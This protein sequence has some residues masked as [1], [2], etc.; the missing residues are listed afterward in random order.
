MLV[1]ALV[2][3]AVSLLFGYVFLIAFVVVGVAHLLGIS[4]IWTALVVGL[5][6]IL[7][8]ALFVSSLS[9]GPGEAPDV[10]DTAL[11]FERGYV[12]G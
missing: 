9:R 12:N 1:A 4:W 10:S 5:H 3:A 7:A 11:R 6:C 2:A 8:I